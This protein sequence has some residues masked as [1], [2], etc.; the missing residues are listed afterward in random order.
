MGGIVKESVLRTDQYDY[1]AKWYTPVLRELIC[2]RNFNDDY[3]KIAR[4]VYPH[5][6]PGEA[7]KAVQLLLKLKLVVRNRDGSYR[8]SSNAV[9][10]DDS[11]V[12]M[13]VRSFVESMLKNAMQA[14]H[15]LE[16]KER[17][18]SSMTLAVKPAVYDTV[19]AEIEAFKD[20]IKTIVNNSESNS[21]VYQ[22][23]MELFPVSADLGTAE[24]KEIGNP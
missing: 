9:A 21:R 6:T 8:Q 3:E 24:A 13:A 11:I 20:R 5:I 14:L 16:K 19:V 18:I 1:F 12:S 7:K 15:R 2:L 10:A 22:F 17:N 4:A 23:N